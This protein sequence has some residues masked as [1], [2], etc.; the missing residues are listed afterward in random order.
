MHY[1]LGNRTISKIMI[2]CEQTWCIHTPLNRLHRNIKTNGV[3]TCTAATSI[4]IVC[5]SGFLKD[6]QIHTFG[7]RN[8]NTVKGLICV[9]VQGWILFQ[10]REIQQ[11]QT[12]LILHQI[13]KQSYIRLCF[14]ELTGDAGLQIT[15]FLL[16]VFGYGTIQ[17]N[18]SQ[19]FLDRGVGLDEFL[20][21]QPQNCGEHDMIHG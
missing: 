5:D 17:L 8:E 14:R 1:S 19:Y 11:R 21:L 9:H 4:N 15:N 10:Q 12:V 7:S 16:Q 18:A 6:K 2:A 20:R 13:L 3:R